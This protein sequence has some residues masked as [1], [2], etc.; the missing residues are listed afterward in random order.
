MPAGDVFCGYLHPDDVGVNFTQSLMGVLGWDLA[1]DRRLGGWASAKCSGGGLPE[2]RND[3]T[4]QFL[5]TECEWLWFV[6]A[7]MGFENHALDALLYV[8]DPINRPIVGGLA[9]AQREVATDGMHGF[10]AVPRATIF[11]YVE[12][13]DGHLKFTGR[14]HYPINTLVKCAATGAAMLVIHR[15]VLEKLAAEHGPT[16]WTRTHGPD[17]SLLGED[18]SFFR[19]CM[20]ADI[21]CHVHTGIRTNHLKRVYLGE[22]D[23]WTTYV[24][25][26]AIV[27]VDVLVPVLHRP[28]NVK[29]FMESL[30]ASTGLATAWW[31]CEPGDEVQIAEVTK[32]GGQVLE[33]PGTFAEKVNHG[34]RHV[35]DRSPWVLLAGDDVRFRAGWLD[36]AMD[37]AERYGAKVVGTNDL[38]NKRVMR[39]EHATHPLIASDYIRE[40]GASWDGPGIVCHEGYRH[41][42]VD[43]EICEVARQRRTFQVALG[44]QVEHWHPITGRVAMDDVYELG[45]SH[46]DHDRELWE[47]RRAEHA[48]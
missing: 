47:K 19:R 35:A 2:G 41:W 26:P 40:Q 22:T 24:A 6:D 18:I 14:T 12:H 23:W 42:Y 16:W 20:D 11:D 1:H 7:D 8:A 30:I 44:A 32:Y 48:S 9:F 38:A 10:S 36:A 21:P 39:G 4:R 28:R 34:W 5:D 13:E 15:S 43:D 31:I 3:I 45:Q 27:N 33:H 25:P 29:P 46:Q 17:G 37:V